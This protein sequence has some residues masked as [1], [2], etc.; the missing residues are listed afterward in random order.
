M[1]TPLS[2]LEGKYQILAKLREGDALLQAG[3][4]VRGDVGEE[5]LEEAESNDHREIAA[6]L[7]RARSRGER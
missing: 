4:D 2:D 3:V 6:L 7:R 1:E 5:A